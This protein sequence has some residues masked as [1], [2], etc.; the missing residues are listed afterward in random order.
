MQL[1]PTGIILLVAVFH[2]LLT[3]FA[4]YA[5]YLGPTRQ[6]RL[7]KLWVTD[8]CGFLLVLIVLLYVLGE[9]Q[10]VLRLLSFLVYIMIGAFVTFVEVPGYLILYKNDEEEG[11]QLAKV[12]E[13][14]IKIGYSFASLDELRRTVQENAGSLHDA[15]LD[16]LVTGFV[17]S[18]KRLGNLDRGY[19]NLT[20]A[21]ITLKI[22]DLSKSSKHP[23]P[24]LVD[25][26]SLAGLSLMIA[27][28]F[29]ALG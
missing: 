2:T 6:Q 13:A 19:W 12:R 9:P 16:D 8:C 21:E 14:L 23:I 20:L 28:I 5:F 27:E 24:K 7:W 25:L 17:E 4:A 29:K 22:D 1:F 3:S 11:K 26:M 18:C 15:R 10:T